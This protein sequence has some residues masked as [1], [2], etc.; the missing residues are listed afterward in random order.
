[1]GAFIHAAFAFPT[2]VYTVAVSLFLLYAALKMFGF[3]LSAIADVFDFVDFDGADGEGHNFLDTMGV[4][5]VPKTI[6]FGVT[7]IF[8]WLASYLGMKFLGWNGWVVGILAFAAGFLLATLVLR[9]F[10]PLFAPPQAT[11]RTEL[12]GRSCVIRSTRVDA[13]TGLAEVDDGGAGFL[14]EVRC[15][16]ENNFT[17]GSKALVKQYDPANGTFLVGDQ[18]W[19]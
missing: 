3:T 19:T 1:M 13:T 6:V 2:V 16:R 14:A 18:S 8:G 17:V 15:L 12:V 5:G 7:S 10:R 11:R 9:P 4:E